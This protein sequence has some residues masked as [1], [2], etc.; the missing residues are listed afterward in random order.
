MPVSKQSA[1]LA[2]TGIGSYNPSRGGNTAGMFPVY[3]PPAPAPTT[4]SPSTPADMIGLDAQ[5]IAAAVIDRDIPIYVGGGIDIGGRIVELWFHPPPDNPSASFISYHA[6]NIGTDVYEDTVIT[7]SRLRGQVVWD[8]GSYVATDK[9]PTGSFDWRPGHNAQQ[10]FLQSIERYGVKAIA[11]TEGIVA[12]W[13]N[14]PLKPFGGI[15]P[16][17]TVRVQNSRYGDPADGIPRAEAIKRV[18]EYSRLGSHEFEVDVSG[19]EPA[20]MIAAQMTLEEWLRQLKS[21]HTNYQ[22]SY[23]DKWRV[24]EPAGFTVA[25]ALTNRNVLRNTLKFRRTDPLIIP[26]ETRYKYINVDRDYEFDLAV[27][28]DD[29]QP[30]PTTMATATRSIELAVATTAAAATADVHMSHYQEAAARSQMEGRGSP[31]LFG[32]EAGDGTAYQEGEHDFAGEIDEVAHDFS[33]WSPGFHAVER[34]KCE[35]ATPP[36]HT[37]IALY[38]SGAASSVYTFTVALGEE[39][40]D[41]VIGLRVGVMRSQSVARIIQSAKL[42]ENAADQLVHLSNGDASPSANAALTT[43]LY[44]IAW[45]TGTSGTVKIT[46]DAPAAGCFVYV[47]HITNLSSTTPHDTAS[48]GTT[49]SD[50]SVTLDVPPGGFTYAL[51]AGVGGTPSNASWSGLGSVAFDEVM[52]GS[53]AGNWWGSGAHQ[54]GMVEQTGR[55]IAVTAPA[56]GRENLIAASLA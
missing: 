53:V 46:V 4:T 56:S 24:I 40:A 38:K 37:P 3:Q 8:N 34:L 52:P 27:A 6:H 30:I 5:Q 21:L 49:G 17:P 26:R 9:L 51:Y 15:L 32:M 35:A 36:V 50:P 41:R 11:Y 45:P 33:T 19:S 7:Q 28:K 1:W 43:G 22:I 18:F 2:G 47:D 23:T 31:A 55:T 12:A 44:L 54:S 48:A 10:P 20:V 42:D 25:A 13:R 29:L 16:L 39:A 14:I